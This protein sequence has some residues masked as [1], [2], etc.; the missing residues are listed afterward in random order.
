MRAKHAACAHCQREFFTAAYLERHFLLNRGAHGR[1]E[2]TATVHVVVLFA[3]RQGIRLTGI[4]GA[5]RTD[6]SG[7]RPSTGIGV[8]TRCKH[9]LNV[10]RVSGKIAT[11]LLLSSSSVCFTVFRVYIY[12]ARE[13]YYCTCRKPHRVGGGGVFVVYFWS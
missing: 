12:A 4:N 1:G 7:G 11:Q 2:V 5:R 9:G 10:F 13:D 3:A 6:G 8:H